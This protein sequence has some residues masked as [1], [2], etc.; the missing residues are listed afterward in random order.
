M[1]SLHTLLLAGSLLAATLASAQITVTAGTG[2]FMRSD[3]ATTA[4]DG[5]IWLIGQTAN[6]AGFFHGVVNFDLSGFAPGDTVTAVTFQLEKTFGG[7]SSAGVSS[8]MQVFELLQPYGSTRTTPSAN[9]E[10]TWNNYSAG[11]TWNTAGADGIGTDR[12]NT[13]LASYTGIESST[14]NGAL[15]FTAE[16]AFLTLVESNLGGSI[17]LYVNLQEEGT[18]DDRLLW[19]LGGV[20]D[21]T[22][23]NRPQLIVTTVPEPST[24]ALLAGFVT[25][26]LVL[27]RRRMRE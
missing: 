11:N 10:V 5:S 19:G 1:K 26:G 13:L 8:T 4:Q 16:A 15:N 14:A 23:A 22:A 18:T 17:N 7:S 21:G 20:Y 27:L 3:Q 2:N 9:G 6:Q 12:N 25:I 24:Y